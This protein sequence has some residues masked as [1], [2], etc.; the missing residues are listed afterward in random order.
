MQ[1]PAVILMPET[2]AGHIQQRLNKQEPMKKNQ[3]T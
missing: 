2:V 3:Q 1:K